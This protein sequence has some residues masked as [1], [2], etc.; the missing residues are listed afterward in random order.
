MKVLFKIPM[1]GVKETYIS[2]EV[3]NI[4]DGLAGRLIANG[5]VERVQEEVKEEKK[6]IAPKKKVVKKKK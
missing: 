1:G 5:T 2:G 6:T 4:E 3:Y